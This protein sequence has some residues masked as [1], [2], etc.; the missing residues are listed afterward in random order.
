MA[1]NELSRSVVS[2]LSHYLVRK[3]EAGPGAYN[4]PLENLLGQVD[5]RMSD[6]FMAEVFARFVD[7]PANP[8]D[9]DALRLYLAQEITRDPGFEQ[10]LRSALSGQKVGNMKG[11]RRVGKVLAVLSLLIALAAD[12]LIGRETAPQASSATA[13]PTTVT[14]VR[15]TPASAIVPTSATPSSTTS[16]STTSEAVPGGGSA[17]P[18]IPGDGSSLAKGT[19][20]LM[21]NLPRPNNE[22]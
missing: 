5:A 1:D 21:V 6:A 7:R 22:W 20:V 10:Q 18:G 19:P 4:A 2:T 9:I 17:T 8:V 16:S 14:V 13:A 11:R 15:T 3:S 12:F